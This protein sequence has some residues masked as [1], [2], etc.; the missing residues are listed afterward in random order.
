M[1]NETLTLSQTAT[2]HAARMRDALTVG[3]TYTVTVESR[4]MG[5]VSTRVVTVVEHTGS[6]SDSTGSVRVQTDKGPRTFNL[7]LISS[8]E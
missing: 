2:A 4:G 6:V 8:V 5:T 1:R 7:W 3:Q